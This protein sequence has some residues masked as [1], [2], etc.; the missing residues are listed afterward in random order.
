MNHSILL[1]KLEHYGLRGIIFSWFKSYLTNRTQVVTITE[2]N[3]SELSFNC[4]VPQDSVLGPLV[5]LIY[6]NDIYKSSEIL[7]FRL[8]ADYTSILL[9]NKNL[10]ALEEVVYSE[11]GKVSEW[12]LANKLFL[13]VSKSNFLLISSRKIDRNIKLNIINRDL[14]R[15]NYA[16]CL[17]VI[18][19][20]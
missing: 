13:N 19:D 6:I 16:K 1:G 17:G 10:D 14:K 18:F 20:N 11:L 8:F 4:G 15:E 7:Q 5:F 2:V 3:A 9:A 12:H